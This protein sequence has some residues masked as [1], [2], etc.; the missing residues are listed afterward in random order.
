MAKVVALAYELKG[1]GVTNKFKDVNT[2]FA[3]FVNA[4][5]KNEI[6]LGK[7]ADSFAAT[8]DVTRGEFALFVYRAEGINVA[9]EVVSVSAVNATQVQVKFNVAVDKTHVESNAGLV[10]INNTGAASAKLSGDGKTATFTF[11]SS[12]SVEVTDGVL[13]VNPVKT[14]KDTS[15]TTVKF[16]RVFTY[17]D[18]VRPTV[19]NTTYT[20]YQNAVIHFSE[21]ISNLGSVTTS[22]GNVVVGTLAADGLSVPVSLTAAAEGSYTVTLVGATDKAGNLITPNPVTVSLTKA[23]TDTVK[24][25]VASV[26]ASGT[27]NLSIKFTEALSGVP[28]VTVTGGG[29]TTVT[30]D[31]T[32]PTKYNVVL[33]NAVT[34]LQTVS[35]AAGYADPSG[36]TGDAYS[37]LVEFKADSTAPSYVNHQ[38]NTI[39]GTQYLVVSYDE[40][41][42]TTAGTVSGS[43]VDANSVTHPVANLGT[44]TLHDANGDGVNE[45]VKVELTGKAAGNYSVT[46]PAGLAKDVTGNTSA[47]RTV[48]FALGT[49]ANSTKPVVSSVDTQTT[50]ANANKITVNF[51]ID[52]T[53]ATALNPN[54][55][56]VEGQNVF[57]AAIF[58]GNQKTVTLTL[59]DDAIT[60]DGNRILTVKNVAGVNG[61]VMDTHSVAYSF[62]ENVKPTITTAKLTAANNI[63]LT[64]SENMASGT[65]AAVGAGNDFEVFINGNKA[66]IASV[67]TVN[68]AKYN[69]TLAN[70]VGSLSDTVTI[71][72]LNTNDVTDAST[73]ANALKTT[74]TVTVVK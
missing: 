7:T 26:T 35:V 28:I 17:K 30:Q 9:P 38:V 13:V 34:G 66:T 48:N 53:A 20:D 71:N 3:P 41:V 49:V 70:P 21:P 18:T 59:K 36:N 57:S 16:T 65:I 44:V 19:T 24:P 27:K 11:A 29:A 62:D 64:F 52:V 55:Y 37:T 63:E 46:L 14:A 51:N 61:V 67:A 33:T 4:L 1:D 43:Y 39:G 22:N 58:D 74:G 25:A 73:P 56:T 32:D 6:T 10:T 50:K 31:G 5:V 47:S 8:A 72:V 69:I 60:I 54:N 45:S 23:K 12:T 42:D 40:A 68:A 15:K 2:T